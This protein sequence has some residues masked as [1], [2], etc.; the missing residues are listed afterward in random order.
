VRKDGKMK[1]NDLKFLKRNGSYGSKLTSDGKKLLMIFEQLDEE[2]SAFTE[3]RF[4]ELI[5]T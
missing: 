3:K 4:R 2:V 1:V 5:D